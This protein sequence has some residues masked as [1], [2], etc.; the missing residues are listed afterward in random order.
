MRTLLL[1]CLVTLTVL[2]TAVKDGQSSRFSSFDQVSRHKRS[3]QG[4]KLLG[5]YVLTQIY[6]QR[7]AM[8]Q[9]RR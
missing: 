4:C 7:Q 2:A 5:N 8:V 9:I 1:L 3:V 6:V